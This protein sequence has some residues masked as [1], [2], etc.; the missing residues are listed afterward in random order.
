MK[1]NNIPRMKLTT[2]ARSVSCFC[3]GGTCLDSNIISTDS[4]NS[5]SLSAVVYLGLFGSSE[6]SLRRVAMAGRVWGEGGVVFEEGG[7]LEVM[8]GNYGR[9][10]RCWASFGSRI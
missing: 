4:A 5:S 9:E 10:M 8:N 7:V 6:G 2:K 3:Q 1:V